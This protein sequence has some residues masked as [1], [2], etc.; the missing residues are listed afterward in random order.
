MLTNCVASA[1]DV[2]TVSKKLQTCIVIHHDL[3]DDG[4]QIYAVAQYCKVIQE[5]TVGYLFQIEE[6][7]CLTV[8]EETAQGNDCVME[9]NKK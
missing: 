6:H 2:K 9:L 8:A 5:G 7:N 3:F 4:S 1:Q